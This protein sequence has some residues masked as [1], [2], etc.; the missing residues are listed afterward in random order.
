M[1]ENFQLTLHRSGSVMDQYWRMPELPSNFGESLQCRIVGG[2][3][4]FNDLW[5]VLRQT[6]R[7]Q[8]TQ[9]KPILYAKNI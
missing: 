2:K 4:L 6:Q 7:K 8:R 9:G 5:A 1:R 3:Y